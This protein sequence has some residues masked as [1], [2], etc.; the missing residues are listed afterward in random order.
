MIY[1]GC[2]RVHSYFLLNSYSKIGVSKLGWSQ[3]DVTDK[4]LE[5]N[6][7]LLN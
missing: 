7:R 5:S 4:F 6:L 3:G 1:S 2:L